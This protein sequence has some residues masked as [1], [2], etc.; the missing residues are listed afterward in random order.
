MR[1]AALQGKIKS[2]EQ[3]Y[4][5]SLA[6][7]EYQIVDFFLGGSLKDEVRLAMLW[8]AAIE[9]LVVW[10]SHPQSCGLS[11]FGSCVNAG[12]AGCAPACLGLCGSH[13]SRRCGLQGPKSSC[14]HPVCMFRPAYLVQVMKIMPVQKQTRAGQRTRFKVRA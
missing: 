11:V 10:A 5:F 3:I 4:L 9:T 8:L 6:V 2:L 7:K 13:L 12:T 14:T 1:V